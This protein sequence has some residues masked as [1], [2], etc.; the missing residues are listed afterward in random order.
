MNSS[1]GL[2]RS[3]VPNLEAHTLK[4]QEKGGGGRTVLPA[5]RCAL[6]SFNPTRA[7]RFTAYALS[8]G[9]PTTELPNLE[10]HTL[11][12]LKNA[13]TEGVGRSY[14]LCFGKIVQKQ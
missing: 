14:P 7:Q 4:M 8:S 3:V 5:Q 2:P 13:K 10:A 11:K 12:T 1:N 6:K 9:L